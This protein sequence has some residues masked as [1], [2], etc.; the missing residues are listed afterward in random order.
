MTPSQLGE[1]VMRCIRSQGDIFSEGLP[2]DADSFGGKVTVIVN[3]D[4]SFELS[5]VKTSG[6]NRESKD[7]QKIKEAK[8]SCNLP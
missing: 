3:G 8:P 4:E 7:Y 5:I 1:I 6:D 2:M